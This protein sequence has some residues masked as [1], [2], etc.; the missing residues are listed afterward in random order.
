MENAIFFDYDSVF[1]SRLRSLIEEKNISKQKLADEIGVS[2]QAIS[3]YCDG[4]TVP[5]ADK[6]LKIAEYFNVSLDFLVGKTEAKTD[7]KDVQIWVAGL[8]SVIQLV[9]VISLLLTVDPT[10]EAM[11]IFDSSDEF[12][13]AREDNVIVLVLDSFGQESLE[14]TIASDDSFLDSL[15]DFTI[16]T[17]VNSTYYGTFPSIT[18]MFTGK[19]TPDE[20]GFDVLEYINS[21]YCTRQ[22]VEFT[23]I[24]HKLGYK[25]R[26]YTN[27]TKHLFGDYSNVS[28]RFDNAVSSTAKANYVKLID[29]MMQMSLYRYMPYALKPYFE[30]SAANYFDEG[31][32]YSDKWSESI[33]TNFDFFDLLEQEGLSLSEEEKEI[34]MIH[35]FGLHQPFGT[36][37]N[38]NEKEDATKQE[39][40]YGLKLLVDTYLGELKRLGVYDKSTIIITSDHGGMLSKQDIFPIL[41]IKRKDEKHMN[42]QVN[43][44]PIDSKDFVPTVLDIIGADN[45]SKYGLSVFDNNGENRNRVFYIRHAL[46]NYIKYDYYGDNE[47]LLEEIER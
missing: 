7:N 45:Y 33:Y 9:A 19:E 44:C 10:P 4:S 27:D 6:L 32:F 11:W 23:D 24:I 14:E 47:K 38:C 36:D 26:Y 21:A 25:L 15:H 18:Y 20:K 22:Y 30:S 16:Y 46:D 8:F 34:K 17:D 29:R 37:S 2:R 42:A 31:I 5:N 13:V 35:L 12:K 40:I 41:L 28:G 3:Q 39:N 43:D 1:S